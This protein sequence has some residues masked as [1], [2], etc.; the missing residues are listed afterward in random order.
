MEVKVC[1]KCLIEKPIDNFYLEKR[2]LDG[3]MGSCKDC[4]NLSQKKWRK[5]NDDKVKYRSQLYYEEN[6]EG[7]KKKGMIYRLENKEEMLIKGKKY[8]NENREKI[9]EQLK[10]WKINNKEKVL[11]G[12][13]IYREKNKIKL[14]EYRQE[15]RVKNIDKIDENRKKTQHLINF[16][17]K[18]KRDSNPVYKLT[19]NM[20]S[21][22]KSYLKITNIVKKSKTFEIVGCTP[23]FL[24]EHLEKQF[25]DGMSWENYG[26]YGWHIDHMIPLSSAKTEEEVYELCHYVN[27]QP[28]W[29]EDNLRKGNKIIEKL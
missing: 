27:L 2:N 20:R 7:I 23:E 11:L 19:V 1:K 5:E 12:Q 8:R 3:L 6:K 24:K 22:V 13:K 29:V 14:Q 10:L 21:R 4:Y 15:Y 28:L 16:Y 18:N 17:L 25:K 26:L 9:N